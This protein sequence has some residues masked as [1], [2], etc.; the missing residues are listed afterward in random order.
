MNFFAPPGRQERTQDY[1]RER[2]ILTFAALGFLAGVYSCIK[3]FK[4]GVPELGYG[5][6]FLTVGLPIICAFVRL[7]V[8]PT[9]LV[10]NLSVACMA[11]Y[12]N[13][14]IYHT[15]GIFSDHIFW[16][17]GVMIFAFLL[18]EAKSG[19]FWF[20]VLASFLVYIIYI[21]RHGLPLPDHQMT[22]AQITLNRYSGYLLPTILLTVA[23]AYTMRSRNRAMEE[24][25]LALESAQ[26]QSEAA[27]KLS[28]QMADILN[29]ASRDSGTLLDSSQSLSEIVGMLQRRSESIVN[30]VHQQADESGNIKQTLEEMAESVEHSSSAINEIQQLTVRS[31]RDVSQS[32]ATM[33]KAIQSMARIR[34]SNSGIMTTMQVISDIADQTNLLALNAAIE[35]ARAGDQGRGFA[36]VADE[37]RTLSVKSNESAQQIRVLLDKAAQDVKEGEE[38]V[39]NAGRMLNDVVKAVQEVAMQVNQIAERIQR[40]RGQ[41]DNIVKASAH[42]SDISSENARS[43]ARL[44]EGSESLQSVSE[45][46]ARI[47][48]TMHSLINQMAR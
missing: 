19:L 14:L 28:R 5:S 4:A 3:W 40:Q 30:G 44:L 7:N 27:E 41:I 43:G 46:L 2:G 26:Q 45:S 24:A 35:A 31:E 34:D 8:L 13:L 39:N 22:E 32:A 42:V 9:L 37:V 12:T 36:V 1:V 48:Q 38:G 6:M 18:T 23:Q 11:F 17:L 10:A 47:A 25:R 16:I 20:F 21:E 29:Q 15:G 33:D